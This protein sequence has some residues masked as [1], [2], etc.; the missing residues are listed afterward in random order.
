MAKKRKSGKIGRNDPCKCGSG[1]KYKVCCLSKVEEAFKNARI[2][3]AKRAAE[4]QEEHVHG[5]GCNH[6]H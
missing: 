6:S 4:N 2:A 3:E 1:N 5:P